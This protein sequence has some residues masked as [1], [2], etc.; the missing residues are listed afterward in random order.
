MNNDLSRLKILS[1]GLYYILVLIAVVVV[2]VTL[3]LAVGA[4]IE[5]TDP[6]WIGPELGE[7][8]LWLIIA[9]FIVVLFVLAFVL[10]LM[11]IARSICRDYSPF[12]QENVKRLNMLAVIS[13]LVPVVCTPMLYMARGELTAGDV[14]G[15]AVPGVLFAAIVYC[16]SLV[17]RYGCWLQ[18]ESDETL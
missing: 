4:V 13:L 5:M 7:N 17:F 14:A 3:A 11:G 12:T 8:A 1:R 10:S 15:L 6:G 2:V 18:K 16:L 9:A